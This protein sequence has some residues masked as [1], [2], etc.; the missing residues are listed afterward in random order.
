MNMETA[1]FLT[2]SAILVMIASFTWLRLMLS[3]ARAL[4]PN[5]ASNVRDERIASKLL[6]LFVALGGLAVT[7]G[8]AVL[9]AP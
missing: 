2:L 5:P 9:V 3:P 4:F 7:L 8:M 6:V 1:F